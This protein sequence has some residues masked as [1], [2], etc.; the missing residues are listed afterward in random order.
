[1]KNLK[2]NK[3]VNFVLT[4]CLQKIGQTEIKCGI[5]LKSISK[6]LILCRL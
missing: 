6:T 1:M 2:L 4:K 3:S 5:R